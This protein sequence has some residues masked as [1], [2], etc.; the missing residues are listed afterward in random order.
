MRLEKIPSSQSPTSG[1]GPGT[2]PDAAKKFSSIRAWVNR[3]AYLSVLV[4]TA[5]YAFSEHRK[6]I[7]AATTLEEASSRFSIYL[8]AEGL[9]AY[10]DSTGALPAT[11]EEAGL[12]ETG[13]AYRTDGST[14]RLVVTEGSRSMVYVE[15]EEQD[16]FGA[17]FHILEGGAVR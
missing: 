4:L 3:F 5:L 6:S 10:R 8:I 14:Y 17:A 9:Q 15:G 2:F 13:I 11:L 7:A 16:H 1:A 12:D